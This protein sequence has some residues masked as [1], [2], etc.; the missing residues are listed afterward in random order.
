MTTSYL[1]LLTSILIALGVAV[2]LRPVQVSGAAPRRL[3]LHGFDGTGVVLAFVLFIMATILVGPLVAA[4]VLLSLFIYEL[5]QALA[6]R[7]LCAGEPRLR[8]LPVPFL[9]PRGAQ[10]DD[11]AAEAFVVL[12]GAGLSL[13]P[14]VLALGVAQVVAGSSPGLAFAL[15]TFG[16]TCGAVNFIM[17]LP[18]L[19]LDGGRCI[20]AVSNSFWPSM[21]PLISIFLVAAFASAA[22]Q[23]QS[24]GFLVLAAIGLQSLLPRRNATLPLPQNT[25]LIVL[26]AYAFTLAAHFMAGQAILDGLL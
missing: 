14:V 6:R 21:G 2:S 9:S 17:L 16:A 20:R 10:S 5:G 26:A 23:N 3:V 25:A 1:I 4:S 11:P 22:L 15:L 24:I 8:I 7:S 13:A 19:P 18:F 12:M